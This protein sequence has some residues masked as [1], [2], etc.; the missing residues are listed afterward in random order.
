MPRLELEVGIFLCVCCLSSLLNFTAVQKSYVKEGK[1][2]LS[3]NEEDEEG[4]EELSCRLRLAIYKTTDFVDGYAIHEDDFWSK[5]N[6][7]VSYC[8]CY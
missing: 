8:E 5:V 2:K 1:I 3:S 4:N 7:I 6:F